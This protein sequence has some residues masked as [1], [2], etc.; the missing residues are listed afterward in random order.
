ML[1]VDN[2]HTLLVDGIHSFVL[3]LQQNVRFEI[4]NDAN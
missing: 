1:Q 2:K 3:V 4:V